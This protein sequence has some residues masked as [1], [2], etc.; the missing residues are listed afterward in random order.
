[1]K[2][3][4]M[5]K[6]VSILLIIAS[7]AVIVVGGLGVKQN[8]LDIKTQKEA[9]AADANA[10]IDK[11]EAGIATL[12]S[13]RAAYEQGKEDL[14]AG[15]AQ[16]DAGMKQL[17]ES[18][19]Q[20]D[21]GSAELAKNTA[22]YN[23]GKATYNS[24]LAQYNAGLAEYNKKK[25]E[26]EAGLAQYT[27]GKAQYDAGIALLNE[28]TASY[29]TA[30]AAVAD[31]KDAY[32]K[33]LAAGQA[34]Y[35]AGLEQYNSNAAMLEQAKAAG[36]LAGDALAEKEALL[37]EAK[38]QL[39]EGKA[40]LIP[41]DTVMG[42][43]KEYEDGKAQLDAAAAQL[44][45]AKPVLDAAPA[46]L[47][48]GKKQLDAAS[49][50]LTAGKAQLQEYEAGKAQLDAAAPQLADGKAQLEDAAKQL[51]DGKAKLTEFEDGQA[52]IDAGI[53]TLKETAGIAAKI[54]GGMDPV[55][56]GREYL[57][58]QTVI[59]TKELT[60]RMIVYGA[61]LL[62]AVLGF[63]AAI[64]GAGA[65]KMPSIGK[66]KG[67][68]L[69]GVLALVFALGSNVYGFMTAYQDYMLQAVAAGA[70]LVFSILYVI[71]IFTYKNALVALMTAE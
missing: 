17:E 10:S 6:V 9:E 52:Q 1:M 69:L 64:L 66:I 16:Y 56:A 62:A 70:I 58:E 67:G 18:Q 20:Y 28:K 50:Q 44:D 68:I 27:A 33:I 25:A 29:Q 7:L 35:D 2:G 42:L 47:A 8:I 24:G 39:D 23:E 57:A 26:Y 48:A 43:I 19:A 71:A 21:A 61:F 55:A 15:Q 11:L 40:K 13:N 4:K 5:L 53:A 46:Q 60:D 32:E 65:A 38:K 22:A 41:Y 54:D 3:Q 45:A 34:Q 63:I 51:A 12:E 49:A 59:T 30:K 31:G 37:A 14:E 36:L